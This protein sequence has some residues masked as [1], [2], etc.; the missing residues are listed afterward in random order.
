MVFL[1]WLLK[2][3]TPQGSSQSLNIVIVSIV[4]CSLG[5]SQM[6]LHFLDICFG[7]K[8][9]SFCKLNGDYMVKNA[10]IN[11]FLVASRNIKS[12]TE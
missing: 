4:A 8:K 12:W 10:Y 2:H 9:L 6:G 1:L 11:S 7:F 5:W 3:S